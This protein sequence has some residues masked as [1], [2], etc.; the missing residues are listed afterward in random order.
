M[1]SSCQPCRTLL[2]HTEDVDGSGTQSSSTSSTTPRSHS[3]LERHPRNWTV[4]FPATT[5]LETISML[6]IG[7][8]MILRQWTAITL[9]YKL[10]DAGLKRRR[11]WGQPNSS[12]IYWAFLREQLQ[13]NSSGRRTV[14]HF[15]RWMS[16]A[17]SSSDKVMV[18]QRFCQIPWTDSREMLTLCHHISARKSSTN[19]SLVR[20]HVSSIEPV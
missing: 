11:C 14:V 17:R 12:S 18:E 8:S 5:S 16:L 20:S 3:P 9:A 2:C 19:Q 6:G 10:W 13:G 1:L 15:N 4:I 7:A